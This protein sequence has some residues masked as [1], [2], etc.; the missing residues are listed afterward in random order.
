MEKYAL[1]MLGVVVAVALLGLVTQ[2]FSVSDPTSFGVYYKGNL[3]KT[4]TGMTIA[5]DNRDG[6]SPMTIRDNLEIVARVGDSVII[7]TAMVPLSRLEVYGVRLEGNKLRTPN[8]QRI[9]I[10]I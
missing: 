4:K 10:R 2:M 1:G 8:E 3:I 6:T 7:G 9:T 5:N